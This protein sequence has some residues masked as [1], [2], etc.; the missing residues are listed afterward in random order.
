MYHYFKDKAFLGNMKRVCSDIM[1]QLKQQINNDSVMQVDIHL[2]GSGAKNLITQNANEPIDLDYNL[3]I[4]KTFDINIHNGR[5]IKEYIIEQ[6]NYV[7][8]KNGWSNCKDST[9]VIS[10]EQRQFKK[11]NHTPFSID[12]A[13]V[14]EDY[15]GWHR[16][17]HN[18]TGFVAFDQY[19]WNDSPQSKGLNDKVI[20][21]K[22][23]HLWEDVIDLYLNK[24]NMY[25]QRNDHNHPSF[26]IYI[27]TINEVYHNYFQ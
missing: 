23:E 12:V 6:F 21:I 16:L 9:S 8:N 18:K 2:V 19:Y 1:N 15:N 20:A 22:N 26:I 3:C 27:E 4:E 5:A 24:K 11:G 14:Y 25:L 17:I 13:I 10:T 7:L